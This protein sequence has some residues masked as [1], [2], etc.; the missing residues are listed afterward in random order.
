VRW[1]LT[2]RE[3][4]ENLQKIER[5]IAEGVGLNPARLLKSQN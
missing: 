1:G 3:A 2:A 4:V 5:V